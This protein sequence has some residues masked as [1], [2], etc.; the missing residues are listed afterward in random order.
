MLLRGVADIQVIQELQPLPAINE[1]AFLLL[2]EL[3]E[4]F[5]NSFQPL[6]VVAEFL[7]AGGDALCF[8]SGQGSRVFGDIGE[9]VLDRLAYFPEILVG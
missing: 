5:L 8:V 6:Q 1:N 2:V 9:L 7:F 4:S 3:I